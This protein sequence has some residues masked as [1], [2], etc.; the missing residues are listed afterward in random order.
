MIHTNTNNPWM[1]IGDFNTIK[2]QNEKSGGTPVD[3]NDIRPFT[4]MLSHKEFM[5]IVS[6]AWKIKT[7]LRPLKA[8]SH[9]LKLLKSRL[10]NWNKNSLGNIQLNVKNAE[11][12]VQSLEQQFDL[13]ASEENKIKL[14]EAQQKL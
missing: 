6:E 11:N 10:S 7:D 12:N 2:D 13:I 5:N 3:I 8:F 9:K 14:C 4:D 1:I